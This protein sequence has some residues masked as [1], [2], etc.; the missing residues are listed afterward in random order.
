MALKRFS[1]FRKAASFSLIFRSLDGEIK[2]ELAPE[3]KKLAY[4]IKKQLFGHFIANEFQLDPEKIAELDKQLRSESDILRFLIV[5]QEKQKERKARTGIAKPK[6]AAAASFAAST[7]KAETKPER[8]KI[9]ELDKKLE[10]LL[11]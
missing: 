4:P 8:V 5:G 1:S 11:K 2:K 9:E 7:F 6:K 3:K 10:E